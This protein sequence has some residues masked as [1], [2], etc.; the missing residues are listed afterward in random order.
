MLNPSSSA[1]K[2][3]D[4]W[5]GMWKEN[6]QL[7]PYTWL[8]I[9]GSA[10]VL[11]FPHDEK[12]LSEFLQWYGTKIPYFLLGAGSNLLIR[13]QGIEGIVLKLGSGFE[14]VLIKDNDIE[15]GTAMLNSVFVRHCQHAEISGFEF[16]ATIPGTLGGALRMNA[17]CYGE[18]MQDRLLYAWV[19]DPYG[20]KHQLS[21]KELGY[22]Y[23]TCALP[24]HWVFLSAGLKGTK[25]TSLAIANTL[26]HYRMKRRQ[27][28]PIGVFTAGSTF[29]NPCGHTAWKLIE[30]LGY[31]GYEKNGA[32]VSE[33]HC[34]FLINTGNAHAAAIEALG[35]EIRENVFNRFGILLEWEIQRIGK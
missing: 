18:E 1:L 2:K 32:K 20:K 33:K 7:A 25:S 5:K 31:R 29:T 13:D 17:G 9:G 6:V 14:H 16:L 22:G 3:K 23:R 8:H 26:K 21:K 35:E 12:E 30:A 15:V 11:F 27:T 19:M 10:S 4:S 34:N 24:N 28:Q